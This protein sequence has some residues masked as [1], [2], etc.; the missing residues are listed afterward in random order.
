[1]SERILKTK[2]MKET[3]DSKTQQMRILQNLRQDLESTRKSKVS[4]KKKK[5]KAI[6]FKM[7]L[8]NTKYKEEI[9][10]VDKEK[11]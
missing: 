8:W 2:R 9:I 7:K 4:K 1:M 6:Y 10:K 3:L 11:S 5:S